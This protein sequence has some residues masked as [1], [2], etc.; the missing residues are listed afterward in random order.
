MRINSAVFGALLALALLLTMAAAAKTNSG[1]DSPNAATHNAQDD[2]MRL[3]GEIRFRSNCARCHAAPPK[4]S[5]RMVSTIVRH[6]RVRATITE[7][8]TRLILH[9]MSE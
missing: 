5:P 8:D 1:K 3:A 4:F 2:T 7:E 9:Y 6:M